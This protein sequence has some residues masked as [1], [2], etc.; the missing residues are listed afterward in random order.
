MCSPQE[1]DSPEGSGANGRQGQ[2]FPIAQAGTSHTVGPGICSGSFFSAPTERVLILLLE[3]QIR[4][5]TSDLLAYAQ[6][7]FFH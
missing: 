3:T 1:P 4:R 2:R 7:H 6:S 5:D